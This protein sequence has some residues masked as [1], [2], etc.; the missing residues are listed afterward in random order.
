MKICVIGN[1][2]VA[3][4]KNAWDEISRDYSSHELNFFAAPGSDLRHLELVGS[5]L[6]PKTEGLEKKL[7][8]T[9]GGET[10]IDLNIFDIFLIYGLGLDIPLLD[11]RL[12]RAVIDQTCQDLI[13][14]SLNWAICNLIRKKSKKYIYIFHNPQLALSDSNPEL[15][16]NKLLYHQ[17][18]EII[19]GN[20][21]IPNVILSLQ[22]N[23]SLQDFWHTS[24]KFTVGSLRLLS[25]EQHPE[26]EIR[27]MNKDFGILWLT[28]F[29]NDIDYKFSKY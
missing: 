6:V 27:H 10:K 16:N 12:S 24:P 28:K 19:A 25:N 2:H 4:I 1:S 9:S 26:F 13:A 20:L 18:T 17:I 5:F 23:E 8:Y 11:V 29:F 22:P 21:K 14:S 15:I 3:A 7:V